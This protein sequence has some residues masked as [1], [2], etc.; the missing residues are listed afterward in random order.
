[1]F[2]R[3]CI[4][5]VT[6]SGTRKTSERQIE[7]TVKDVWGVCTHD[8]VWGMSHIFDVPTAQCS[9]GNFHA[10]P[11]EVF[12]TVSTSFPGG[13][14]HPMAAGTAYLGALLRTYASR[15]RVS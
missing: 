4:S 10:Y 14:P 7:R 6:S 2:R 11:P 8:T 1:M 12:E 3:L 13:S 5:A 9:D 15:S